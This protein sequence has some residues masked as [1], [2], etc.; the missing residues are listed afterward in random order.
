MNGASATAAS[1]NRGRRGFLFRHS[2]SRFD[3]MKSAAL[4]AASTGLC[5]I[6][7]GM[8]FGG[9]N[10]SSN[11]PEVAKADICKL[12]VEARDLYLADGAGK[13]ANEHHLM[14]VWQREHI[15]HSPLLHVAAGLAHQGD[16]KAAIDT[17]SAIDDLGTRAFTIIQIAKIEQNAGQKADAQLTLEKA[18]NVIRGKD[19]EDELAKALWPHVLGALLQI[20]G[21]LEAAKT[22]A[23]KIGCPWD[24]L[25][26]AERQYQLAEFHL[27]AGDVEKARAALMVLPPETFAQR[28]GQAALR[29]D[30]GASFYNWI[31]RS[32]SAPE[33]YTADNVLLEW[34]LADDKLESI[35]AILA[36]LKD[37]SPGKLSGYLDLA[38]RYKSASKNEAATKA[39]AKADA[40]AVT[41]GDQH[42][43]DRLKAIVKVQRLEIEGKSPSEAIKSVGLLEQ[44]RDEPWLISMVP[45][46]L[47]AGDIEMANQ[48]T[49]GRKLPDEMRAHLAVALAKAGKQ[50]EALKQADQAT[51]LLGPAMILGGAAVQ[52]NANGDHAA[53]K[54]TIFDAIARA[55]KVRGTNNWSPPEDEV[56]IQE[57]WRVMTQ[58]YC[59]AV[60]FG[61]GDEAIKQL[62]GDGSIR[63]IAAAFGHERD[64]ASVRKWLDRFKKRDRD[65][66]DR[67][68]A[69]LGLAEG[70]ASSAK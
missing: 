15:N 11:P 43:Q 30:D 64:T 8:T 40:L 4:L 16:A 32:V 14:Y 41:V 24:S 70:L 46:V 44:F 9:D 25:D 20:H 37:D 45:D 49:G 58:F 60:G 57:K 65:E 27:A 53:A 5:L 23:Q 29:A 28:K 6:L 62:D 34:A 47:D 38:Q 67:C 68:Y 54:R 12:L 50:Q 17:A 10:L 7:R 2:L 13:K 22:A 66:G 36:H 26:N 21:D 59:M 61:A 42:V 56:R 39:L 18:A 33:S 3:A 1:R 69:L 19:V 35:E 31:G 63:S 48:I 52:L 55:K 51:E